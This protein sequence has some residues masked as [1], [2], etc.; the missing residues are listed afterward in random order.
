MRWF[1][2]DFFQR[3]FRKPTTNPAILELKR[4]AIRLAREETA[5]E[6]VP[7]ESNEYVSQTNGF[8]E[9]A[10]QAAERKVR[11]LKFSA[12]EWHDFQII[13]FLSGQWNMRVRSRIARTGSRVKDEQH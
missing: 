11:M 10:I 4:A 6:V 2:A 5:T 13:L 3:L 8:V 12:G 9:Q 7:E 1:R